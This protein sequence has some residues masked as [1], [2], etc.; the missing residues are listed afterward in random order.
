MEVLHARCAGLDVHQ[1]T[2][3][4]CVRLAEGGSVTRHHRTFDT[5]TRG[6]LAL[7][8]WLSAH[9]CTHVA[10]EATG[11]YWKPVWHILE[12]A[13]QLVLANAMHIKNVPGRKTDVSDA[14]WIADLLAHGL[15]RAS[16]VPGRPIQEVRALTRT[17]KQL[18]R[19][20]AAR[21][22]RIHKTLEDANLKIASVASDIMGL[23]GRAILHALIAGE[24]DPERLADLTRGRL[25]VP[26]AALVESLR[27]AVTK[28][29]RFLLQLHLDHVASLDAAIAAIDGELDS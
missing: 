11:V 18:V 28:N 27:G 9:G 25:K 13:F 6:L 4:A 12:G 2:V 21:I 8:E 22:Q 24:S 5:S 20:K 1:E 14:A 3:V 19:E 16:F 23:S 10:L 26:R 17:R 7:S 15:I 29:H